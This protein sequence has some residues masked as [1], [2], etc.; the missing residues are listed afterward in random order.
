MCDKHVQCLI[1]KI[2]SNNSSLFLP[3]PVKRQIDL[4]SRTEKTKHTQT[5]AVK[6][7]ERFRSQVVVGEAFATPA[8]LG[9]FGVSATFTDISAV[10]CVRN[11]PGH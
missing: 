5:G 1:W 2:T 8:P 3:L 10:A 4:L 9:P 6:D 7:G 11:P